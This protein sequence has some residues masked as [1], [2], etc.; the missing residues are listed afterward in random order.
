MRG[1]VY[2]L[3]R[4]ATEALMFLDYH[5]SRVYLTE[6]RTV[7]RY[8]IQFMRRLPESLW[9]WLWRKLFARIRILPPGP[10][11]GVLLVME[12]P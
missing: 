9:A 4:R 3:G 1:H 7:A 10:G 6:D 11:G 12:K 8:L 5:F 2:Y